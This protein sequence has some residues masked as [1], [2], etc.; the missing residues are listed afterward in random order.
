MTV[1]TTQLAPGNGHN[2]IINGAFDI[3]QRGDGPF[4]TNNTYTADRWRATNNNSY[5]VTKEDFTPAELEAIG[6]GDA[7]SYLRFDVTG[8]QAFSKVVQRVEDV[9]TLAGQA[10]TVS[11]YA[12]GTNPS[13]TGNFTLFAI[14]NFGSG[15]SSNVPLNQTFS[16]TSSWQ[17]FELTFNSLGS[18]SGKT[19]GDGSYFVI[20]FSVGNSTSTATLDLWGV[21]LEAG[22]VATPFKR[23]ANS[24]QGELAAC[25]RYYYRFTNANSSTSFTGFSRSTTS[26]RVP[27]RYPVE[28]RAN[29]TVSFSAAGNFSIQQGSGTFTPTSTSTFEQRSQSVQAVFN[30]TGLTTGQ[31]G[32]LQIDVIEADAE[33]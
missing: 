22:S 3:W 25:Q 11:F 27:L 15:G 1:G 8:Q 32:L 24:I 6:Y 13:D 2:Y 23:N 18:L 14:Q 16:V 10:I 33:L 30:T 4:T 7:S 19:I 21:Q 5:S 9:R 12:K 28:M 20:E 29:A 26:F 17:R 31:A